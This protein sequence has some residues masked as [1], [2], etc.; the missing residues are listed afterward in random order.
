RSA[1]RNTEENKGLADLSSATL[2]TSVGGS[3][4]TNKTGSVNITTGLSVTLDI[5]NTADIRIQ[6]DNANDA[7][8]SSARIALENTPT[9]TTASPDVPVAL[10][11]DE[12]NGLLAGANAVAVSQVEKD[13]DKN[14]EVERLAKEAEKTLPRE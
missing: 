2:S 11:T 4:D 5:T 12:I 10:T 13:L 7:L 8:R 6:G 1:I 3:G 14:K 9:V